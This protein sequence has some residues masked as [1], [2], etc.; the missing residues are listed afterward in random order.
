MHDPAGRDE[1][2]GTRGD[3]RRANVL[4]FPGPRPARDRGQHQIGGHH[5]PSPEAPRPGH[6]GFVPVIAAA[7]AGAMILAAGL[8]L[9]RASAPAPNAALTHGHPA[10]PEPPDSP[11]SSP[12]PAQQPDRSDRGTVSRSSAGAVPPPPPAIASPPA[13]GQQPAPERRAHPR[14]SVPPPGPPPSPSVASPMVSI[15]PPEGTGALGRSVV[16]VGY[17]GGARYACYAVGWYVVTAQGWT[18][19]FIK[20]RVRPDGNGAFRTT[21]LQMGSTDETNSS[22]YA[23]VLGASPG[24]CSWLS[25]L[26][27]QTPTGE[28][29]GPWPPPGSTVL[30][31]SPDPIHRTS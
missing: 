14:H 1:N 31:Q 6:K 13:A 10:S 21:A 19:Y 23:Y 11:R 29:H 24:G 7:L 16:A 12:S 25:R 15:V 20:T 3:G 8:A 9:G 28:Y 22:W 30:Y 5:A 26:W 17:V 27:A 18:G 2:Q 4:D